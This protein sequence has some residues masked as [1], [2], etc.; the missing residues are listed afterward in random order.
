MDVLEALEA[1]DRKYGM[2]IFR[3]IT[4]Y[5]GGARWDREFLRVI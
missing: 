3:L 2:N 1:L 4:R 5:S